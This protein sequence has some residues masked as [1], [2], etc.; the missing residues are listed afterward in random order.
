MLIIQLVRERNGFLVPSIV[1]FFVATQ[2]KNGDA[3]RVE[4]I[5]RPQGLSRTLRAQ[6]PHVTVTRS[7]YFR[8]VWEAQGRTEFGEQTDTMCNIILLVVCEG[9]P[10]AA[11]LL[12]EFDFPSHVSLCH[13]RNILSAASQNE[14][15]GRMVRNP[16]ESCHGGGIPNSMKTVQT[17][18]HLPR[19]ASE[20]DR[21]VQP[22]EL[23]ER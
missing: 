5:Q 3:Q 19:T 7:I 8:T 11:E 6:F 14:A 2:E 21:H 4:G 23:V 22:S 17:D 20:T 1:A 15:V 12:G 9:F 13:V 18:G 10:P 16:V